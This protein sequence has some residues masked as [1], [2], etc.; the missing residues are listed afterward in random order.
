MIS[1]ERT[2][3]PL[4]LLS[5]DIPNA[6]RLQKVA[7]VATYYGIRWQKSVY[8]LSLSDQ[9]LQSL[10]QELQEVLDDRTDDVRIFYVPEGTLLGR[11]ERAF[12]SGLVIG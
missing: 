8:G 6:R 10:I 3:S 4:W 12:L 9:K 5:Y 2:E 7:K 1:W 11:S